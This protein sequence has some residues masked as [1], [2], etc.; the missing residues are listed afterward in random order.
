MKT[1][2][3]VAGLGLLLLP[4]A[5]L[6]GGFNVYEM[7]A[8]ATALGGAFTATADDASAIFYNPA[9]TAWLPQGVSL[10]GNL[11]LIA[12]T[13]EFARA[14][15]LTE[16]LY[17]GDPT[18]STKSRVYPPFGAY[19]AYRHDDRWSGGLGVFSPFGLGVDW[20]NRETFAGRPISVNAQIKG[21]YISPVVTYRLDESFAVSFGANAVVTV[22][23]LEQIMTQQAGTDLVTYNVVNV[24]LSG[25]SSIG[26][27]PAVGVMVRAHEKLRFGVNYKGGV[28]NDFDDGSVNLSQVSTGDPVL[29]A[30]VADQLNL[31]GGEGEQK[32]TAQL[33]Y[34]DIIGVGL[35]YDPYENLALMLDSVFFRWSRF[36]EVEL[37]FESGYAQTLVFDYDDALQ[38][39][40]GVEYRATDDLR[41]MGG[42]VYD[43]TPQ[44]TKSVGPILPDADRN[45]FSVGLTY[46]FRRWEFTLAYMY[47]DFKERSTVEGTIGRQKDGFEGTYETVAHIPTFGVSV[48]F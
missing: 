24:D 3:L 31:L 43:N 45:D 17:P 28:T 19:A 7:G 46:A 29:D 18:G 34:P 27:S 20:E 44:P 41:I 37:R 47:V 13:S 1:F 32:A 14:T 8:R 38:W 48:A 15:G 12:P 22:L 10:N 16:R 30:A 39:R 11:A 21:F 36:D 35:R 42:Y 26:W 40:F 9:G 2:V 25:T 23:D 33:D 5:G 4:V 6:A